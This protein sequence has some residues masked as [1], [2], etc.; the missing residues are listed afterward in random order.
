MIIC[1]KD[2]SEECFLFNGNVNGSLKFLGALGGLSEDTQAL[3]HPERTWILENS[4]IRK[5]KVIGYSVTYGTQALKHLGHSSTQALGHS[6][7]PSVRHL[8]T[9]A[10]E[11]LRHSKSVSNDADLRRILRSFNRPFKSF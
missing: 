7:T 11:Y 9:R 4:G 1:L 5:P 2:I 10:L 8:G 6:G 3:E